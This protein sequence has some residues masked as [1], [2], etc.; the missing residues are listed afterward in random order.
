[1]YYKTR[2]IVFNTI[3]LKLSCL[4]KKCCKNRIIKLI[5]KLNDCSLIHLTISAAHETFVRQ[6]TY[7]YR[8]NKFF[9]QVKILY[10]CSPYVCFP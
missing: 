2:T 9:E 7:T 3:S 4:P 5:F 8:G 6:Y 10:Y 1:M